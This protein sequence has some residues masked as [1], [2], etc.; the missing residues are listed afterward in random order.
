M[1]AVII[2]SREPALVQVPVHPG[3]TLCVHHKAIQPPALADCR[4]VP[5]DEYRRDHHHGTQLGGVTNLVFAGLNRMITP[6]NRIDPAWETLFNLTG[7][8]H[9]F[10]VDE[11]PYLGDLWRLWFHFG[12]TGTPFGGYSYSYLLESHYKAFLAGVRTDNP[13]ALQVIRRHSQGHVHCAYDRYFADPHIDVLRLLPSVHAEYQQ[14]K[15]ELFDRHDKIHPILKGLADFTQAHCPE[16][17]IPAE[18]RIFS[19]PDCVR[20]VRTDLAVDE[21]LTG[22]LLAKIREVNTVVEALR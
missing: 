8:I 19:T 17:A 13:L 5:W 10:S 18:H 9:R 20:I 22:K 7:G 1:A 11:A 12:A 21:Y 15:S 16:R 3:R 2:F 6:S 14:L 4:Y